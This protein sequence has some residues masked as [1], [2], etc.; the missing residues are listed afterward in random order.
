MTAPICVP[1]ST[2]PHAACGHVEDIR[3]AAQ[4][5]DAVLATVVNLDNARLDPEAPAA[6][7]ASDVVRVAN[8]RL[9]SNRRRRKFSRH[10]AGI[11]GLQY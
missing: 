1:G 7:A 6:P 4:Q 8:A 5:I 10:G 3:L 9:L 2:T 11:L